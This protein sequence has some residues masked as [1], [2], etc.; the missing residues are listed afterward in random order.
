[1]QI[2]LLRQMIY[3]RD[4]HR[5]GSGLISYFY[6]VNS[7]LS[8]LILCL[9]LCLPA[10][11]Q[12]QAYE[13]DSAKAAYY[14][15]DLGKAR[16]YID[17]AY[18]NR[19]FSGNSDM[20]LYR[21]LVYFYLSYNEKTRGV[22]PEASL[23][24]YDAFMQSME[25]DTSASR[26]EQVLNF[27][28][29]LAF[30]CHDYGVDLYKA[31][32]FDLAWRNFE[33]VLKIIP[34]DEH[35]ILYKNQLYPDKERLLA[36]YAAQQAGKYNQAVSHYR[37]F[38]DKDVQDPQFYQSAGALFFMTKDTSAALS[39]LAKGRAMYPNDKSLRNQEMQTYLLLDDDFKKTDKLTEMIA[40]EPAIP[41]WYMLRARI[42]EKQKLTE[43]AEVDFLKVLDINTDSVKQAAFALGVMYFDQTI[44]FEKVKNNTNPKDAYKY[45]PL[46]QKVDDMF[47]KS[48]RLF[49]KNLEYGDNLEALRYLMD[50]Y[51]RLGYTFQKE[52]V[53][54]RIRKLNSGSIAP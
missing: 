6:R 37:Y 35:G 29:N 31:R 1:M 36:A 33:T 30:T 43:K 49:N 8:R 34:I 40:A 16:M 27:L 41:R 44:P 11:I 9:S 42:Y 53:Q 7:M 47:L 54:E 12:A 46:K 4:N 23:I 15:G 39:A 2:P 13:L 28:V 17:Q 18:K 38:L 45:K 3:P 5:M 32:K 14:H 26:R 19:V 10:L 24:A 51:D 52:G 22:E 21:G 48:A 50:I 25:I 20:H